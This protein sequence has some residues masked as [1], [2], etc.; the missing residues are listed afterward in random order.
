MFLNRSPTSNMYSIFYVVDSI[1]YVMGYIYIYV[2]H[3]NVLHIMYSAS[4]SRPRGCKADLCAGHYSSNAQHDGLAASRSE[5]AVDKTSV[6]KMSKC[7][8]RG[9]IGPEYYTY[10]GF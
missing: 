9:I 2:F 6:D 3:Y 7:K 4:R 8:H 5:E 10:D 1:L